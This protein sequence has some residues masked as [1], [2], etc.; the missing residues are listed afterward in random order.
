MI[1]PDNLFRR[2]Q[3]R[4]NRIQKE[5]PRNRGEI[6]V[7][8]PFHLHLMCLIKGEKKSFEI[9]SLSLIWSLKAK[10]L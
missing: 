2:S 5:D 1:G 6:S 3:G 4:M 8:L 9:K 10:I 7:F